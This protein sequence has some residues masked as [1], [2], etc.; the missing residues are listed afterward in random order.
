MRIM[1]WSSDVCSSDRSTSAAH[2]APMQGEYLGGA[3]PHLLL[4]GRRGQP[5]WWSPFENNAGNHNIAICG[6]SGSGKSVL[7]QE[8]CAALRGAGANVVVIDD[9]RSFEHSVKLQG[10]RFVEFTLAAGFSL[11]PFS[12]VDDARAE[13]DEAYRIDCFDMIKA[14]IG[15]DRQS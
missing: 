4:V 13:A 1:D 7:L 10:G 9:G 11:N 8:L 15:Q 5:F 3:I 2:I 12:M 6:K 14:L